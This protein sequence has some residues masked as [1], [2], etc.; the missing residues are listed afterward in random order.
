MGAST[1]V[2]SAS[3][4]SRKEENLLSDYV[5][6]HLDDDLRGR[7]IVINREVQNQRRNI[8]DIRVDAIEHSEDGQAPDVATVIIEVK[9]CW[10]PQLNEAMRSQ[11][12]EHYLQPTGIDHGLYLVGWFNCDQWDPNDPRKAQ[13]PKMTLEEARRHF[14]GQ[15]DA[16]TSSGLQVRA[17]VLDASLPQDVSPREHGSSAGAKKSGPSDS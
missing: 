8:T 10:H 12:V 6:R 4:R 3:S 14:G 7:G 9:G 16:L 1:A 2:I 15:A 11:L 17:F 5:K 13:T